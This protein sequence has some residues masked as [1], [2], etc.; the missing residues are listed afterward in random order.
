MGSLIIN[1]SEAQPDGQ[2]VLRAEG[3]TE[4]TIG[5]GRGSRETGPERGEKV[6]FACTCQTHPISMTYVT[7]QVPV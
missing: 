5:G 7:A 4:G 2:V 6:L 3:E 1:N